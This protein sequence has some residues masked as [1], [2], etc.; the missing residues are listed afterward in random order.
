V[1]VARPGRARLEPTRVEGLAQVVGVRASDTVTLVG[2][3]AGCALT[4]YTSDDDGTTWASAEGGA[5]SWHLPPRPRASLVAGP[6]GAHPAPCRALALSPV[7]EGVAR[8]LCSD[9]VVKGTSDGGAGWN[10]LGQLVGAVDLAYQTPGD[11]VAVAVLDDC[12]A[13]VMRTADG[14]T[15]WDQASCL[16]G[17]QAVAVATAGDRVVAMAGDRLQLSTDGGRTWRRLRG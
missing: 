15:T 4:T 2:L 7:D 5:G 1:Q 8:L 17:G 11:G 3:D 10:T 16:T 6:S 14:G 12:D 9:G 13:A